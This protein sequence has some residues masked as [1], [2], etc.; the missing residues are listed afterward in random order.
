ML[1]ADDVIAVV[2]VHADRV[3]DAVRRLGCGPD[4]ALEI[5]EAS[6]FDLLDAVATRPDSVGDPVGWW[7][8]RARELGRSLT[9]EDGSLP[10]GGG[11][12]AGDANQV[13]LAEALEER[14][15]RERAA[16]LLRDSYDL[17]PTAVGTVLS[18]DAAGAMELVG[19]ARLAFLPTLLGG[20][21]TPLADH[22]VDL[23]ALARLAEGGQIAAR[24]ATTRRH[25]QSCASCATVVDAQERA[26]R[27]LSGL[28]VVALPDID[29]E[30]LLGRVTGRARQTLPAAVPAR[31]AAELEEDEDELFR[32][33]SLSLSALGLVLAVGAGVLIGFLLTRE[34]TTPRA[35]T[36]T[37]ALVSSAPVLNVEVPPLP[38][39][40]PTPALS[41]T[42]R[43]FLI[44]PS[45]TPPP[46]ATPPVTASPTPTVATEPLAL[47]LSPTSGPNDTLIVVTGRGFRPGS[48]VTL[49]Y[50]NAFGQ[51]TGSGGTAT[52]DSRGRFTTSITASDPQNLPG[53]HAV[54]ASDESNT[55]EATFTA[56]G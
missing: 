48:T 30:G 17:P 14:P 11:V 39:T 26:R 10:M 15:E 29:R 4:A 27:L 35:G 34:G 28:T 33:W 16:L 2:R 12:L 50:R 18:L 1:T 31:S 41:P 21:S 54:R 20:D 13:R 43:V 44:T 36:S 3:H 52:V 51:A 23:G 38:T 22:A 45:P 37:A 6:A 47:E 32:R 55:I 5:V 8:A 46:T 7:F 24:D 42:P 53:N 56:T 19:R 49:T 9:D 25:V 40:D